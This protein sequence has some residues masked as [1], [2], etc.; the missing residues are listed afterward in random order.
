[1][2]TITDHSNST[3]PAHTSASLVLTVTDKLQK[4]QEYKARGNKYYEQQK[5]NAAIKKYNF[6]FAYL[7][8]RGSQSAAD[9]YKSMIPQWNATT[10]API[11]TADEKLTREHLKAVVHQNIAMCYLKQKTHNPYTK[12]VRLKRITKAIDHCN[13]ALEIQPTSWKVLCL[14]A[15]AF[16]LTEDAPRGFMC[17]KLAKSSVTEPKVLRMIARLDKKMTRLQIKLQKRNK[18]STTKF[19]K[20]L[21]R[22][23]S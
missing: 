17:L 10:T 5:Y 19:A 18:K 2:N 4:A 22:A 21:Q 8:G 1:M 15:T 14:Q 7:G 9:A 23:F 6:C 16:L 20:R 12:I 3:S 11:E 13:W